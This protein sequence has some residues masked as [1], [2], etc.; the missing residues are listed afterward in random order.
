M[1]FLLTLPR[2]T[3][4]QL[5]LNVYDEETNRDYP[6]LLATPDENNFSYSNAA[7]DSNSDTDSTIE[8]NELDPMPDRP[9]PKPPHMD[10]PVPEIT[11]K[12]IA[13]VLQQFR[14]YPSSFCLNRTN[15]KH[16]FIS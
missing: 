2:L 14:K 5:C 7:F 12:S 4:P 15:K 10:P 6:F 9:P 8:H 16:N 1:N 11:F 13:P 3:T